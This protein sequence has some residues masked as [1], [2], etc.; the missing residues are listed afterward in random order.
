MND[1][2]EVLKKELIKIGIGDSKSALIALDAGSSQCILNTEY[3]NELQIDKML[4]KKVE[5]IIY[6][7]YSGQLFVE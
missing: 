2:R 1:P 7:F 3:L 5:K 6:K 4:R